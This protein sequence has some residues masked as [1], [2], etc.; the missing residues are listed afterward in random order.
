MTT[1]FATTENSTHNWYLIDASEKVLGRLAVQIANYLR[2]KHKPEFTPHADAGDYI[3]VINAE[4]VKVT[5]SKAEQKMYYTHS[6]YPGGIKG[7]NFE[8]LCAK[9]AT[10]I[11]EAAVKGMLP[12]NP[13]GRKCLDK[14]KIYVGSEHP[15]VA[16]QPIAINLDK[17]K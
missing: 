3:V 9:D 17:D 8:K 2:G 7:I 12:K 10:R 4:K 14:L 16:Q 11:L 1:Y 15:H 5:G 13:L 6:E